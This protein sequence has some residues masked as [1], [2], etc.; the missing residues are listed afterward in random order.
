VYGTA[1]TS[2]MSAPGITE[3]GG[4]SRTKAG[5]ASLGSCIKT[6]LRDFRFAGGAANTGRCE[7]AQLM[8]YQNYEAS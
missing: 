6:M 7:D 8:E 5:D 4:D 1:E 2:R 3:P